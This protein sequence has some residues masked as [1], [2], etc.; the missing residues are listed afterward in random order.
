MDMT[1][2]NKI[3][4]IHEIYE[5]TQDKEETKKTLGWERIWLT[6]VKIR[7][8]IKSWFKPINTDTGKEVDINFGRIIDN[9]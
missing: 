5:E 9:L 1:Y 8:D 6:N 4:R 7:W 3:K 2:E